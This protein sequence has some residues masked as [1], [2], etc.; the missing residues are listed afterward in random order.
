[1]SLLKAGRPSKK[2]KAIAAVQNDQE[3]SIRMNVNIPKKFYKQ[4]KQKALNQDI[5]VKELVLQALSEYM[6]K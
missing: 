5:T 3:E 6:S 1:M 2:E 4:I